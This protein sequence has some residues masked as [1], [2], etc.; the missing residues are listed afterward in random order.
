MSPLDPFFPQRGVSYL[1]KT[2]SISDY[3]NK[4]LYALSMGDNSRATEVKITHEGDRPNLLFDIDQDAANLALQEIFPGMG[5][6]KIRVSDK[7]G[8]HYGAF[9]QFTDAQTVEVCPNAF[10]DIIDVIAE[11]RSEADARKDV[12]TA[13]LVGQH[14]A[15]FFDDA[16]SSYP[17]GYRS[18]EITARDKNLYHDLV[19]AGADELTAQSAV[20]SRKGAEVTVHEVEHIKQSQSGE[21]L[22]T[23]KKAFKTASI[24]L[25]ASA[26]TFITLTVL[27]HS[28]QIA[29]T[30][31]QMEKFIYSP[32]VLG[33]GWASALIP[34]YISIRNS[35]RATEKGAYDKAFDFGDKLAAAIKVNG[36][37]LQE[38]LPTKKA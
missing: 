15:D 9:M 18:R 28:G 22:E 24:G 25:A 35:V 1:W 37:K 17:R 34:G 20:L 10:K 26:A 31:E 29:V 30:P 16:F 23:A 12:S 13:K 19:E 5:K 7:V 33:S 14:I 36:A 8:G 38:L 4:I 3:F 32:A 11:P 21:F 2:P 6:L 27:A